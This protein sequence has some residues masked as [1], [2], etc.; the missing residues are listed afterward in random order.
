[1][2][3]RPFGFGCGNVLSVKN[4]IIYPLSAPPRNFPIS[5]L[6]FKMSAQRSFP[7]LAFATLSVIDAGSERLSTSLKARRQRTSKSSLATFTDFNA[8]PGKVTAVVLKSGTG[9]V[10]APRVVLRG[11]GVQNTGFPLATV[12]KRS[13]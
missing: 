12:G 5:S 10:S 4:G 9:K 8:K 7:L 11:R 6:F 13:L 1:M 2:R 3:S